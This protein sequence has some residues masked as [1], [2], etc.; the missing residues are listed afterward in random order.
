MSDVSLGAS[1]RYS[2]VVD[3]DV[4]KPNKQTIVYDCHGSEYNNSVCDSKGKALFIW[5]LWKL[6]FEEIELFGGIPKAIRFLMK[7]DTFEAIKIKTI[8]EHK[9]D[10]TTK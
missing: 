6:H 8:Q 4:K 2:L 10:L 9:E 3:E 7:K 5:L 1:P